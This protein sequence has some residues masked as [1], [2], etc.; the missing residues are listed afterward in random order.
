MSGNDPRSIDPAQ[1]EDD[2]TDVEQQQGSSTPLVDEEERTGEQGSGD[3]EADRRALDAMPADDG[4]AED[5]VVSRQPDSED[6]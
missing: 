4:T 2:E 3:R 6:H 1:T 5:Q